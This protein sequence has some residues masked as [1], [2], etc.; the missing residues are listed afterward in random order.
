MLLQASVA[1]RISRLCSVSGIQ[2]IKANRTLPNEEETIFL[3]DWAN[4]GGQTDSKKNFCKK[5]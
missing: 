5:S 2:D 4:A 3:L 1:E